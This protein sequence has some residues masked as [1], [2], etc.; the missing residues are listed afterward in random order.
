[1]NNLKLELKKT[2]SWEI[3]RQLMAVKLTIEQKLTS[4]EV[5]KLL[6]LHACSVR[7]IMSKY[8]KEGLESLAIS[9]RKGNHRYLSET[10][11]KEFLEK[12]ESEALCWKI[13]E[14][15]EIIKDYREKVGKNA[16]PATVYRL[17]KRHKWRKIMPRSKHPKKASEK[18]ILE[19]KKIF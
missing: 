15:S 10:E 7:R 16:N 19:W 5:G 6:N 17:L 1:M 2:H 9:R 18:E 13:L 3:K 8:R 4:K 12:Y 14:V 11:E